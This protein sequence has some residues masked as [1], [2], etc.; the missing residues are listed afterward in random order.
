MSQPQKVNACLFKT[1]QE[2]GPQMVKS[3]EICQEQTMLP[4][5]ADSILYP[6]PEEVEPLSESTSESEPLRKTK[7]ES[8][9]SLETASEL[10]SLLEPKSEFDLL[11]KL[12]PGSGSLSKVQSSAKSLPEPKFKS[13]LPSNYASTTRADCKSSLKSESFPNIALWPRPMA[14]FRTQIEPGS[15]PLPQSK[16]RPNLVVRSLPRS[17]PF[18]KY[19]RYDEPSIRQCL[20]NLAYDINPSMAERLAAQAAKLK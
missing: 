15:K 4:L 2:L 12:T 18:F 1:M 3:T 19:E 8:V 5:R 11:P 13:E 7:A 6:V 16:V 10:K 9:P 17:A 14:K 20:L